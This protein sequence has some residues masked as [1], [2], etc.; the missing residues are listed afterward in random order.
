MKV[1]NIAVFAA[2]VAVLVV[3]ALGRSARLDGDMSARPLFPNLSLPLLDK[4]PLLGDSFNTAAAWQVFEDYLS[5]AK[6]HDLKKLKTLSFRLSE[7]C[8]AA[9]SEEQ[10][11]KLQECYGLMDGV[12]WI[13]QDFKRQD[14][15]NTAADDR[16]I[17][18]STDYIVLQEGGE[19]T[20]TVLYFVKDQDAPKLLS[21]RFCYGAD[22]ESFQ[23][24]NTDPKTRDEDRDGWWNDIEVLMGK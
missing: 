21:I 14:F 17:I 10:P 6:K 24:V 19:P 13:T 5:A 12:Y 9:L 22:S 23:C 7:T 3:F 15:K 20:K 18:L 2:L 4:L 11:E 16:Q 8:Q 1:K